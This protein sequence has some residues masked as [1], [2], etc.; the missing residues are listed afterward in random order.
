MNERESPLVSVI[1][2]AY[3]RAEQVKRAALSVLAQTEE[4]LELIVVD[5]GSAD[6]TLSALG[7]IRDPRLRIVR[8]EHGGACRARNRGVSLA[9]GKY[10]AFQDS[11]DVWRRDKL[12]VQLRC[13][14]ETG[15]EVVFCQLM[16]CWA[17]R[18]PAGRRH[19]NAAGPAGSVFSLSL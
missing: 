6:D 13:L 7:E 11:D 4:N 3:N 12:A 5:D 19:P 9:R 8:Q 18:F 17:A 1:L 10:A 14:R 15:A 2:P 16:E